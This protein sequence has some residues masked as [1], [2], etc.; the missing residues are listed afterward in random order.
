MPQGR[1]VRRV[2]RRFEPWSV[3]RLSVL[4]YLSLFLVLLV[5]GVVLWFVA[6]ATGARHHIE[7]LMDNI[8][9][10]GF[11]FRGGPLL[12][13]AALGGGVLVVVGT[14]ANLLLA[15]LYNLISDVIGGVEVAVLEEEPTPRRVV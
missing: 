10:T 9:F 11:H 14:G 8:G 6:D 2:I 3:L 4:F 15:V 7:K 5:A 12:E 1:R 13:G